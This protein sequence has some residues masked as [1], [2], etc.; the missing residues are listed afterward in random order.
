MRPTIIGCSWKEPFPGWI[1]S[2]SAIAAVILYTGVGI[3]RF[4]KGI[5][6]IFIFYYFL[7]IFLFIFN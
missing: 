6:F 2:V 3:V 1:D 5:F 7:F 4:I